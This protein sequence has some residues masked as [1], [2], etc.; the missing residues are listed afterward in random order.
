MDMDR[1][2]L[3]SLLQDIKA[4]GGDVTIPIYDV[5]YWKELVGSGYIESSKL[6]P[7]MPH[8]NIFSFTATVTEEGER[9]LALFALEDL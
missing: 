6:S 8:K 2:N 7:F 4:Y 1:A 9:E 5:E 3:M